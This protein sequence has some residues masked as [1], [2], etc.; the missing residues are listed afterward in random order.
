MG[1]TVALVTSMPTER[2]LPA[3]WKQMLLWPKGACKGSS[4]NSAQALGDISLSK[5]KAWPE[6]AIQKTG[7]MYMDGIGARIK[8]V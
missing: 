4:L 8:K 6:D 5:L 1:V 2:P 3:S 7:G